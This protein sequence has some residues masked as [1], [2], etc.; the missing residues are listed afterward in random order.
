MIRLLQFSDTH[1]YADAGQ[2]FRVG[3]DPESTL[4]GLIDTVMNAD[5]RADCAL[6]T[7]DLV[8]DGSAAG[9]E[10][11]RM[12]LARLGM[13]VFC[14]AGN[15]DDTATMRT[16]LAE[17]AVHI[18]PLLQC[19]AWQI[20][21][22][23]ST[24]A[25]EAGGWLAEAELERLDASLAAQPDRP[26]LVALHHPPL[27]CGSRWMDEAMLLANPEALFTVTDRHPQVRAITWGHIHQAF[28]VVR[29]GVR[30][31]AAPSTMVQFKR[32]SEIFAIDDAPPACRWFELHDDGVF[33]TGIWP[34]DATGPLP[35][36]TDAFR[37]MVSTRNG[38]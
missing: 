25:G 16:I 6:V 8:H 4:A 38:D 17:G 23:D 3:I 22:L 5:W 33:T 32:D 30:C 20:V 10:R 36:P 35:E 7:G 2:T 12:H 18:E 34:A 13:P 1:L 24:V 14:L 9:Y 26:A 19:G 27:P 37:G 28:N 29:R 11:L 15:H 31:L 21:L